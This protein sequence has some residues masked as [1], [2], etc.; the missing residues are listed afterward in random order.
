MVHSG[1]WEVNECSSKVIICCS[2]RSYMNQEPVFSPQ[3][4]FDSWLTQKEELVRSIKTSNLKDQ[5]EM[6]A[7]LRRLAVSVS[8]FF[9]P[10][11]EKTETHTWVFFPCAC[12]RWRRSWS[13]RDPP[14]TSCAPWVRTCCPASKTKKWP[15][16]WRPGWTASP[17]A[18]TAS[19]RVWRWAAPRYALLQ[20]ITRMSLC[21]RAATEKKS[22]E[23]G[24]KCAFFHLL[25]VLSISSSSSSVQLSLLMIKCWIVKL[26]LFPRR[27]LIS[28]CNS[29]VKPSLFLSLCDFKSAFNT[30]TP[31]DKW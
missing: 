26:S 8:S 28:L 13:W 12:R 31:A 3:C 23:S 20:E 2:M 7:C 17:S 27:S 18:G 19:F 14:W 21:L 16:N 9:Y 11:S 5:A 4:L 1:A 29:S 10:P 22:A 25:L 15:A 30:D 6:V 24:Q